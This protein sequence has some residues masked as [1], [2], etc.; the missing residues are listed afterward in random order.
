MRLL[1]NVGKPNAKGYCG[2]EIPVLRAVTQGRSLSNARVMAADWVRCMV[3][4]GDYKIELGVENVSTYR[5]FL[6]CK[7]VEKLIPLILK[8][9]RQ[10]ANLSIRD[11]VKWLNMTSP[12]AY[13]RYESGSSLP[14]IEKLDELF[15]AFGVS[16]GVLLG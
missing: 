2:V 9:Q 8:R 6:V 1:V 3:D 4:D 10:A 15:R 13:A 12:N 11:V 7:D 14:G 5:F 16:G